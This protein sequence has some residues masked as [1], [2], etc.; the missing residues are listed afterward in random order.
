ML[1][2]NEAPWI[3]YLEID[4]ET[5]Q[6]RLRADTPKEIRDKYNK[7]LLEQE[8]YTEELRPK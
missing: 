4:E 6:R 3:E 2:F 5:G 8:K 1:T 7:Y